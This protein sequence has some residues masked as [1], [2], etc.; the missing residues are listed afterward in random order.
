MA[1]LCGTDIDKK[2]NNL[3]TGS[4]ARIGGTVNQ[5]LEYKNCTVVDI[6]I[7]C[8][9]KIKYGESIIGKLRYLYSLLKQE[10]LF[11][12][13][14]WAQVRDSQ[15]IYF[16]IHNAA[17]VS[18]YHKSFD[19][20]ISSNVAE[21]SFNAIYFFLNTWL[22]TKESGWQFHAIPCNRF[23]FDRF[24][25]TTTLEHFIEDFEK[26]RIEEDPT[27]ADLHF[28]DFQQSAIKADWPVH[29]YEKR[30]PFL[31]YHVFDEINTHELLSLMFED[32]TTDVIKVPGKFSDV[33][34]LF[35]NKLRSEFV[36]KYRNLIKNLYGISIE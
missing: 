20:M 11:K 18:E 35:R 21:H 6:N 10:R 34:V 23:T 36:E 26:G 19:S 7:K 33:V 2:V 22:I 14:G 16:D 30:L 17:K 13:N 24:R 27:D 3:I 25:S 8:D 4:T 28:A 31:H 32:V 12:R 1:L 29:E 9:K 15:T 5:L